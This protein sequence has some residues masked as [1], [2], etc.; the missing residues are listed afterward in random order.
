MTMRNIDELIDRAVD[1]EERELLRSIGEE[2]GFVGQVFGLFRGPLGW[3]GVVL[4]VAQSVMFVAGVWASWNFFEATDPMA[5]LRWG[6]P[7]AVLLIGALILKMSLWPTF[8]ANR[9]LREIKRLEWQL[10]H[11]RGNQH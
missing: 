4:I 7:A 5:A 11:A 10:S 3:V 8:E 6:M 9:V 1:E 2:R